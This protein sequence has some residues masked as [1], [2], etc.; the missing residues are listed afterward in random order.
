MAHQ[1]HAKYLTFDL[2]EIY[3]FLNE[4]IPKLETISTCP[5]D[6]IK[7]KNY[8]DFSEDIKKVKKCLSEYRFQMQQIIFSLRNNIYTSLKGVDQA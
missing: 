2:A 3:R 6:I 5:Q 1:G 4:W 8:S 7:G